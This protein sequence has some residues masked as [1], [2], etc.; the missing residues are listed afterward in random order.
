MRVRRSFA[1]GRA[2]CFVQSESMPS[3]PTLSA[4]SSA[5]L[6][7][8]ACK[9]PLLADVAGDAYQCAATA[10]GQRFPLINGVPVLI[11]E[12]NSVFSIDDFVRQ[13]NTF[14][15]LR[16]SRAARFLDHVTPRISVN[17]RAKENF[18]RFARLLAQDSAHPRVLILGGSVVGQGMEALLAAPGIDLIESDVS[19]GPRTN[20]ICDGHNIPLADNAIDGVVV[21]AV[22]EHVVDPHAVAAEIHRVLKPNGLV[23]AETP[24]MQQMHGGR[25]D[26]ERFSYWG[27]RRLFRQFSE[28]ASGVACGPAMALAWSYTYFLRSFARSRRLRHVLNFIGSLTSFW[29]LYFDRFLID[30]PGAITAASGYYFIG[31]KGEQTLTDRELI[32]AYHNNA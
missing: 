1:G 4:E 18:T 6:R 28:V 30:R 12:A 32:S 22:L 15:N 2:A 25:Y 27:H 21:Q 19:F 11:N 14:F 20:L 9:G 26:F 31:R 3:N 23:Y 5:L 16:P 8:P 24:F 10:C 29:L 17:L 13:R 7:C